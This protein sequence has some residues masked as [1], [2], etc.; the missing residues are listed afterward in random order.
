MDAWEEIQKVTADESVM[1]Y[2]AQLV[3]QT[4]VAYQVLLG[5]SPRASIALLRCG[6]TTAALRGRDF[7]TPDDI[8]S[9]ALPVLRHR[10]MLSPESSI[11]GI[12]ADE[13]IAGILAAIPVPR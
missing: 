7:V 10:L 1:R 3:R 13:V 6:K 5:A 12:K 9:V 2:A 11:E 4:R 8:K